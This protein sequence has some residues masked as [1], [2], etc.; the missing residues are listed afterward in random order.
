MEDEKSGESSLEFRAKM[1]G[2]R[3][4]K[5]LTSRPRANTQNGPLSI[6]LNIDKTNY[7]NCVGA[8]LALLEGEQK[9]R[10]I[11]RNYNNLLTDEQKSYSTASKISQMSLDE[12]YDFLTH[13][14]K[15][16]F[17]FRGKIIQYKYKS[18]RILKYYNEDFNVFLMSAVKITRNQY[19][20]Y[21]DELFTNLI[22]KVK[23][24]FFGTTFH[25][26]QLMNGKNF[27]NECEIKYVRIHLTFLEA[28]P[29]RTVAF[30]VEGDN[31]GHKRPGIFK[32]NPDIFKRI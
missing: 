27:N 26:I 18:R 19:L 9:S 17:W 30:E 10:E 32:Q 7:Q 13:P 11:S 12:K 31:E 2:L 4:E 21:S 25:I 29:V 28:E 24:N 3:Y 5:K 8:K 14:L 15:E 23:H 6:S 1:G 16:N 22:G 20:I